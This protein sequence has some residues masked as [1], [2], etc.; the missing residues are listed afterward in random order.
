[1]SETKKCRHFNIC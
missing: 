1:M